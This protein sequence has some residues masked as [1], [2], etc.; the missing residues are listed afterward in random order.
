MRALRRTWNRLLGSVTGR[1]RESDLVNE[2]EAHIQMQTEDNIRLGMSR[3]DARREAMLKFGGIE[4]AK[5]AYRDQRG[6]PQLETLIQDLRYALRGLRRNPGFTSIALLTLALGIGASTA[7][8][9]VMYAVLLRPLPYRDPAKLV[10]VWAWTKDS[11][12]AFREDTTSYPDYQDWKTQ[13]RRFEDFAFFIPKISNVSAGGSP[14]KI[15]GWF[16]RIMGQHGQG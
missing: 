3:R 12:R 14:E 16:V 8:F 13:S 2:I 4:A 6:L 9:S 5:E 15:G 1:R 11:Q 10:M 7:I